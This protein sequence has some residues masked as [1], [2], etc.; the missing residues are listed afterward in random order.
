MYRKIPLAKTESSQSVSPKISLP[1][2]IAWEVDCRITTCGISGRI[3]KCQRIERFSAR[4]LRCMKVKRNIGNSV[5]PNCCRKASEPPKK[6]A[7]V[8]VHRRRGLHMNDALE[9]PVAPN[10]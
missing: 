1:C 3:C 4:I 2:R 5:W 10:H 6:I 8:D 7:L 9:R